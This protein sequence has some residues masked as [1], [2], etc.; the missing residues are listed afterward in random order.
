[1]DAINGMNGAG[2]QPAY[3]FTFSLQEWMVIRAGLYE[4]AAKLAVPVIGKLEQA[5]MQAQ[6]AQTVT[7]QVKQESIQ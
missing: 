6:A 7:E 2:Q 4:L 3:S 1:M 5:L